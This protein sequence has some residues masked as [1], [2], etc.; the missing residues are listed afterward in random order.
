MKSSGY[1][2]AHHAEYMRAWRKLHPLT[3]RQRELMAA[4]VKRYRQK[5]G[6]G[7]M[8]SEGSR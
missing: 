7:T 1:C 2:H 6:A 5:L 4:R 8:Q 3:P